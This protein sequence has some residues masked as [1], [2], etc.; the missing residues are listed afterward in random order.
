MTVVLDY[1]HCIQ[2]EEMYNLLHKVLE[3]ANISG[4]TTYQGFAV[5]VM[6]GMVTALERKNSS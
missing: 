1:Y 6:N 5:I 4:H 3:N 2:S